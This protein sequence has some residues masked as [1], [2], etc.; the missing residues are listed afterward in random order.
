MREVIVCVRGVP[1]D[2]L[3]LL[4]FAA[5]VNVCGDVFQF[6]LRFMV[7]DV[8]DADT[9]AHKQPLVGSKVRTVATDATSLIDECV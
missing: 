9:D 6:K 5:L 8:D 4:S 3:L 1:P 2:S 7:D